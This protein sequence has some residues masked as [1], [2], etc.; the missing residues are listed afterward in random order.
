MIQKIYN[1]NKLYTEITNTRPYKISDLS[2]NGHEIL[3][4]C[5]SLDP[6]KIPLIQQECLNLVFY[7]PNKN[8][9]ETLTKFIEKNKGRFLH[10]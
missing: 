2:I 7:A 10:M 4:I 8:T 5:P 1:F 6:V 9:K 3:A